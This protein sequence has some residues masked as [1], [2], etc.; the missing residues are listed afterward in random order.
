MKILEPYLLFLVMALIFLFVLSLWPIAPA[1]LHDKV[2][3]G[4]PLS[5]LI[6]IM[7][8]FLIAF[9]LVYVRSRKYLYSITAT[10]IHVITTVLSTLFILLM[11]YFGMNPTPEVSDKHELMG[12]AV[13]FIVAIF[14]VGQ[15]F[16]IVNIFFGWL[17]RKK[18]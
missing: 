10:W 5:N 11:V 7:P 9:W 2:M 6:W 13:Q 16:Y 1:D 14:V 15:L 12:H 3:F 18:G 4:I 17:S 8:L